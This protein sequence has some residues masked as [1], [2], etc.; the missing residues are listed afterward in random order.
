MN[1][2][3]YIDLNNAS[4]LILD[5]NEK[6]GNNI[7]EPTLDDILSQSKVTLEE[8]KELHCAIETAKNLKDGKVSIEQ[9]ECYDPHVEVADGAC[10][11]LV[12]A[13][14]LITLL[15]NKGIDIAEGFD[16]VMV[17]NSLKIFSEYD[18]ALTVATQLIQKNEVEGG[19]ET[20]FVDENVDANGEMWFT[21]KD[22]NGKIRKSLEHP[23]VYLKDLV[24]GVEW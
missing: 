12:T 17:N 5:W 18:A 8:M 23:T 9:L 22:G 20:F 21:V 16:R 6:A 14:Q 10:D 24:E 1:K 15:E 4:D 7:F 13:L 11:L 2:E 19:S 3:H